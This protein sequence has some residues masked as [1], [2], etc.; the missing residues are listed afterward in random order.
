MRLV[1]LTENPSLLLALGSIR[2]D[3]DIATANSASELA[4]VAARAA[5]GLMDLGTTERGLAQLERMKEAGVALPWV[6]VGDAEAPQEAGVKSVVKPFI[7][8]NLAE[9]IEK[10]AGVSS[11]ASTPITY[12]DSPIV[13]TKDESPRLMR[14]MK[15][16]AEKKPE[17]AAPKPVAA[18]APKPIAPAAPESPAAKAPAPAQPQEKP[19]PKAEPVPQP[20]PEEAPKPPARWKVVEP[21]LWR[22]RPKDADVWATEVRPPAPTPQPQVRQET[23]PEPAPIKRMEPPAAP[24]PSLEIREVAPAEEE[25]VPEPGSVERDITPERPNEQSKGYLPPP[26]PVDDGLIL[27]SRRGFRDRFIRKPRQDHSENGKDS[28]YAL[29][30][31]GYPAPPPA[32]PIQETPRQ[33]KFSRTRSNGEAAPAEP[34]GNSLQEIIQSASGAAAALESLLKQMPGLED[35]AVIGNAIVAEVVETLSPEIVALYAASANSTYVLLASYGLTKTEERMIVPADHPFFR[36]IAS[37]RQAVMVSPVDL[38]QGLVA[39]IAGARTEAFMA[40]PFIDGGK[41]IAILVVGGDF[42]TKHLDRLVPI[43]RDGTEGL[44]L[45]LRLATLAL[46]AVLL[47]A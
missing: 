17:P 6:V 24:Q 2:P 41:C 3:W 20:K 43:T 47:P 27:P 44:A 5:V 35:P 30:P 8:S 15:S 11:V 31:S 37:L 39:G 22:G 40:A 29:S 4:H 21:G 28:G 7:L 38:V 9:E 26:P 36:E 33:P 12:P 45:S 10:T 25:I 23:A 46:Q 16:W 42:E 14:R 19:L 13:E 34:E 1:V 18:P 32:P